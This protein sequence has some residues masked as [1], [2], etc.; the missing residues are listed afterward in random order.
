MATRSSTS[1]Y[2]P[3][4]PVTR[5]SAPG[6]KVT[7]RLGFRRGT[8]VH[9]GVKPNMCVAPAT[10]GERAF[11]KVAASQSTWTTKQMKV[12]PAL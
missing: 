7:G 4:P 8:T 5:I 9:A 10:N 12:T 2:Q 11:G 3:S 1:E 6:G